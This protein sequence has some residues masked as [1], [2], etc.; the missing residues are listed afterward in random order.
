M[1]CFGTQFNL[2]DCFTLQ[3]GAKISDPVS[4]YPSIVKLVS[5]IIPNLYLASG[6]VIF[7]MILLGGFTIL[8]SAKDPSKIQ[9]GQ[10]VITSAIIGFI[11][12]F[13]S[14]WIIQIIQVTTGVKILNS[15]L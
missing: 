8:T 3:S 13:A 7:F 12:I 4:G 6:L 9:E 10:K 11:L 5:N 14:Y 1:A 15:T 2:A